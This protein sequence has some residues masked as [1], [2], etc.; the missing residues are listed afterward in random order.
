M[1]I[2]KFTCVCWYISAKSKYLVETD[3]KKVLWRKIEKKSEM[4]VKVVPE[5]WYETKEKEKKFYF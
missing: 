3:S 2:R 4:I 5:I 1:N